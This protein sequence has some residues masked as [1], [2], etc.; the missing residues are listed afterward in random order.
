MSSF[1]SSSWDSVNVV[2]VG[3]LWPSILAQENMKSM[4]LGNSISNHGIDEAESS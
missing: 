1:L 3:P 4:G 2:M